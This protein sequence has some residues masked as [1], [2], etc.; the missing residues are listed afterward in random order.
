MQSLILKQYTH[1]RFLQCLDK[2]SCERTFHYPFFMDRPIF[3]RIS[4][5]RNILLSHSQLQKLVQ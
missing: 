2:N 1:S 5:S 3:G 4:L